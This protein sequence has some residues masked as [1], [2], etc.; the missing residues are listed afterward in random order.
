MHTLTHIAQEL[1]APGKGILAADESTGTA[2]KRLRSVGVE[3]TAEMRRAY[4]EVFLAAPGIAQHLSGVILY[5]ETIRDATSSGA[6]FWRVLRDQGIHV[7]IKVDTGTV[8]FDRSEVEEVTEGLEGLEDRLAEYKK[9]NATFAKWRAV[10]RIQGDEYPTQDAIVEN[11][12]RLAV[13]ARLCQEAGI[14]PILEPEVLLEG[15]H[16]RARAAEVITETLDACVRAAQNHDVDLSAMLIKSSMALSGSDSACADTA[17]HVA[18]DTVD[19]LKAS[20]PADIPGI[21]F[22][23]GGQEAAQ[24]VG[25]LNAIAQIADTPW[26]LTYSFARALQGEA[27]QVWS[28]KEENIEA[29]QRVFLARL[30]TAAHARGGTYDVAMEEF[31]M[32]NQ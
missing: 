16:T 15:D 10:I 19:A 26:E 5:D 23:S 27:L 20:V 22:L 4:R 7:G 32:N 31:V 8:P 24:A 3:E 11:A 9:F 25:N 29:A 14:V 2:N 21:V 18:I 6:P 1:V 30:K 13:Y 28:G 12:S 17:E